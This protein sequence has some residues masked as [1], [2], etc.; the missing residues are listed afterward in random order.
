MTQA[1]QELILEKDLGAGVRNGGGELRGRAWCADV[2]LPLGMLRCDRRHCGLH[3]AGV[4][5]F[6]DC[7]LCECGQPADMQR[8]WKQYVRLSNLLCAGEMSAVL[9]RWC[10]RECCDATR[11]NERCIQRAFAVR[12]KAACRYATFMEAM[13]TPQ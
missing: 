11:S 6:S 2:M 3:A 5:A 10:F 13:C 7:L 12:V 4:G 9:M 1:V 8:L